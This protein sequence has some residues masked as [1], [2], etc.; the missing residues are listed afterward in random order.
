MKI[1]I[2]KLNSYFINLDEDVEKSSSTISELRKCGITKINRYPAVQFTPP[3]TGL[4]MTFQNLLED[5]SGHKRP[6]LI[7]EDDIR[8]NPRF[9][10]DTIEVPDDADALYVG[11]T[12]WGVSTTVNQYLRKDSPN[13]SEVRDLDRRIKAT[14]VNN[15]IYRIYNMLNAHAVIMLN[16]RYTK[17]LQKAIDIAIE[18]GGHQDQVRAY[19]MPYWNIYALDIPMFS[20]ADKS[21]ADEHNLQLSRFTN[22]MI[23]EDLSFL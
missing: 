21:R 18:S 19:T 2:R 1:K 10:L 23:T 3:R 17:F 12:Y 9:S 15:E 16:S 4:A 7:C 11:I 14:R 22:D 5:I 13:Y 6:V 20:Q 8:K